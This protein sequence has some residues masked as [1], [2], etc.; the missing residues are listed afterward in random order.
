MRKFSIKQKAGSVTFWA[1][2]P[3]RLGTPFAPYF[4]RTFAPRF[5][6]FLLNVCFAVTLLCALPALSGDLAY[7]RQGTQF[8]IVGPLPF[9]QVYPQISVR[10]SGGYIVWQDN[11]TDGD[12]L[13]VSA[14][15]LDG[16]FSGSLSNFRVNAQGTDDQENPHVAILNN[17]GAVFVWQGGK[18]GFQNIYARFIASN[19]IWATGDLLVNTWTNSHRVDPV[20]ATLL[21]GNVAVVWSSFDQDGSMQGIYAQLFSPTGQKIGVETL[22]NQTT[23]YNQRTPA[24]ASLSDGRFVVAWV[25][26]QQRFQNS[27]DVYA[28]FFSSAGA[29]AG[30]EFLI[31]TG[32]N[33]CANPSVA[34]S[35][36][37]GF[38]VA[39]GQKD[40]EVVSNSW[41]VFSRPISSTGVGGI[42]RRVNTQ[43][44]GD[45]F[46]P[47]ISA[48]GSDFLVVWT[49]LGQ[50]NS[51]EGV[52]GQFLDS[53]GA[54]AGGELLVNTTT[55]GSQIHPAIASDGTARFLVAWTSFGGGINSFDLYAQRYAKVSQPL[56]TPAAP[57]VTVLASNALSVSWPPLAGFNIAN[58]EVHADNA[59][60]ATATIPM[61]WWTMTGL[62]PGSTHSFQ[63]A[64]VLS[65]GRRS[66]LS[67][68]ASGTTYSAGASWGGI[69]QEWML[70]Y[71]GG[72][73]F[74][75]P[76][77]RTDSDGDGASN[78]DEFLAG[79]DPTNANSVLRVRLQP[80]P[81]GLFLN[82]NTEP[83]FIY[84]VQ[85]STDLKNWVNVGT[86]RFAAGTVDSTYVGGSNANYY[87]VSRLR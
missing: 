83:G 48:A 44:Y 6:G 60:N 70:G 2:A 56:P 49:S 53:S 57:F 14:R 31:N 71:F 16:S 76:S 65:D 13:G 29:A 18:L 34:A 24:I 52:F 78:L 45:Q 81:Q 27:V 1:C 19:G 21:N 86:P 4:E 77:P 54:W 79:T 12:G 7:S 3:S 51:H 84:Q 73:M 23:A 10:P 58:Y 87:R 43:S 35:T 39:W 61:T 5:K 82:W 59:A 28:R 47:R 22:I 69:P 74:A 42:V 9:D 8:P 15:R 62:A 85:T 72:D 17:G 64:Y 36:D 68:P 50:D 75:W 38:I 33:I 37:G 11:I 46:A 20:V 30:N 41:D 55:S 40:L 66:S 32:T 80:S 67:P 63:I 25:S 26:E